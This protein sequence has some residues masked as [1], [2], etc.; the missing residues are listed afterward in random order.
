[1]VKQ[2]QSGNPLSN[3]KLLFEKKIPIPSHIDDGIVSQ[4]EILEMF[5]FEQRFDPFNSFDVVGRQ[6]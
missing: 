4:V 6:N 1:M 3:K 2:L 5:K